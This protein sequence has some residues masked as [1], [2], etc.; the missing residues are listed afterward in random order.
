MLKIKN[1]KID[2]IFTII[3]IIAMLPIS[4]LEFSLSSIT[5]MSCDFE[6]SK[7]QTASLYIFIILTIFIL[8]ASIFFAIKKSKARIKSG[9]VSFW[10]PLLSILLSAIAITILILILL[11]LIFPLI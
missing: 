9:K 5:F 3:F 8:V 2:T 7:T 10:I 4:F 1:N 6:C 11:Y